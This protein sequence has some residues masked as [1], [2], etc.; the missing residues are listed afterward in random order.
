MCGIFT[1]EDE[2]EKVVSV[3]V[4]DQESILHIIDLQTKEVK[5]II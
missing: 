4:D 1:D 2:N 3:M 5:A